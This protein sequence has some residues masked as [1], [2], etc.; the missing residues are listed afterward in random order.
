MWYRAEFGFNVLFF[1][2]RI[3]CNVLFFHFTLQSRLNL[4]TRYSTRLVKLP[5]KAQHRFMPIQFC[6]IERKHCCYLNH[7]IKN[8]VTVLFF[9]VELKK[10]STKHDQM[11]FLQF[12][13]EDWG[14]FQNRYVEGARNH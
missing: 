7:G 6:L 1:H 9:A 14:E 3:V 5:Q 8:G 4:D 2:L 13:R 10:V 11:Y 12:L